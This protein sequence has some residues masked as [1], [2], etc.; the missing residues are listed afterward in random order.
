[1]ETKKQP[2]S[3]PAPA[4][5]FKTDIVSNIPLHQAAA[6]P[7]PVNE[8]DDID[9]AMKD[10]G[11]QLK[12]EDKKPEKRH[13]FGRKSS[14]PNF[15]AKP[16]VRESATPPPAAAAHPNQT[17]GPMPRQPAPKAPAHQAEPK[18]RV[19]VMAILFTL[20]ITAFLIVAALAAFKKS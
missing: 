15:S 12:Q 10:V 2:D 6:A 17:A 5:A 16:V 9:A 19:P 7:K 20:I 13:W 11:H 3:N 14:D 18:S 4:T 1:M 8:A